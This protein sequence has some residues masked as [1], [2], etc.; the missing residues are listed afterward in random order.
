M[1]TAERTPLPEEQKEQSQGVGQREKKQ[2]RKAEFT[3]PQSSNRK[4]CPGT[5][6]FN[7]VVRA[8]L[9]SSVWI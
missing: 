8:R 1:Q 9:N 5:I 7:S 2:S 4:I 6:N 3:P